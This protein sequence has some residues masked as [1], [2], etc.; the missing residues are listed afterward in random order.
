MQACMLQPTDF[1]GLPAN[2]FRIQSL[3]S[4]YF[5]SI[6]NLGNFKCSPVSKK[7]KIIKISKNGIRLECDYRKDI[8]V[9]RFVANM[10]PSTTMKG[11][12]EQLKSPID[13][14]QAVSIWIILY[15]PH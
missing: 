3:Q 12:K 6:I 14:E 4:Y 9:L 13:G 5:R 1:D 8:Y 7:K 10:L 11:I 15:Q 2:L